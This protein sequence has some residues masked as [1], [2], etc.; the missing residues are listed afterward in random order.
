MN[1]IVY[2]AGANC[3]GVLKRFDAD[4]ILCIIDK[5]LSK[6]GQKK[7]GVQIWGIDDINI[8]NYDRV[9][10][11]IEKNYD[12]IKNDLILK[13]VPEEKI[14]H[15]SRVIKI[16]PK[17]IGSM[18]C[19][20]EKGITQDEIYDE[21]CNHTTELSSMEQFFLVGKHNRSYKWLHYFEIYNNHFKRYLGKDITILEIGVNRCG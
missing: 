17:N 19:D 11:S 10:V 12:E 16:S 21:L 15:Y 20:W 9:I 14:F 8:F 3:D 7:C 13:G 1:T 6:K 4:N 2:G 5:D 18:K